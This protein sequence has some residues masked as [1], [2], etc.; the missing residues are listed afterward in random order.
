M[1]FG[2]KRDE[3]QQWKRKVA[4]GELAFLTHYWIH[5][6]YPQCKTVTKAG[7]NDLA[8]L[9]EWGHRYGLK[10]E[11]IDR[12]SDYPHFDLIGD[13]QKEILMK[14]QLTNHLERFRI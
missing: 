9:I 2:I 7:C 1:A 6:K 12:R 14:E 13:K 11:W 5:P 4:N 3:L 10:E 8:R